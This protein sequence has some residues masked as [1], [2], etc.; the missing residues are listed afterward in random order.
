MHSAFSSMITIRASDHSD[1]GTPIPISAEVTD[2]ANTTLL[3]STKDESFS[4]AGTMDEILDFAAGFMQAMYGWCLITGHSDWLG[5]DVKIA[6][7]GEVT[8]GN[9]G[10]GHYEQPGSREGG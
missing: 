8:D 3:V 9:I 10:H 4:V 6:Q 7:N 2:R 1:L 5:D